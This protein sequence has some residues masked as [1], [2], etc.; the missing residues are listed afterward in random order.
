MSGEVQ[1][2]VHNADLLFLYDAKLTNPN[3]DPDDENRPRMDPFTR[4]ALVSD[5][6]LKRY[7]RDYWLSRGQDV[8][9][10]TR[11]DGSRQDAT[12]REKELR[13][14]YGQETGQDLAKGGTRSDE[15]YRNWFLRRLIDV[16]LFGATLPIKGEKAEKAEGNRGLS[17]QYT[18]PV[19]FSWGY[20]LHPVE[21]NP[22]KSITSVFAG[23][24]GEKG[25]YGTIGKDWRLLYAL[26]A[27]W[28]HV[29]K[30]RAHA[31]GLTAQDLE[32]LEDALLHALS[33]EAT[34]RSKIGQT[35]RLYLRVDW[36]DRA[37]SFSDPRE[38]LRLLPVDENLPVERWRSIDEF[39]LDLDALVQ[40][41]ER[42][43]DQIAGLRYWRH[44][45]LSVRGEERLTALPGFTRLNG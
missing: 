9:V 36:K 32:A 26:I 44:D 19:Q 40:R 42:Y 22:S 4:R 11:E 30:Q 12:S 37:P 3:G 21:L 27:F 23:R 13:E 43:R 29:A 33:S 45:E 28:G 38:R 20:S 7:L 17:E 35:P 25:E 15:N 2:A 18:G 34:T 31:T 8:W 1:N 41:L 16:R 39:V 5:V 24:G 14:L 10:R 6:R